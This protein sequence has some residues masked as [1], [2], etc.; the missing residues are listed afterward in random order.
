MAF[1]RAGDETTAIVYI[2]SDRKSM[3][4]EGAEGAEKTEGKDWPAW[5]GIF[6]VFLPYLRALCVYRFSALCH[7][8]GLHCRKK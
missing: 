3:N 6:M 5:I 8:F 2:P 4:A 1:G 7:Y